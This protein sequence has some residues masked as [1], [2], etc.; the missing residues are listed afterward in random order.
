LSSITRHLK[1]PWV[2]MP[3]IAVLAV[4][5]WYV[6]AADSS[7]TDASSTQAEPQVIEAT[8]GTMSRTVAADGTVAAAETEDLSFGA[9]GTVTAV[10]VQ[11]GDAVTA[12]QVLARIDSVQLKADVAKAEASLADAK[13]KRADD[14][15]ADASDAQL[16][17]DEASITS[18]QDQLDAANE[19]LQGATLV[20]GFDGTV[21]TVNIVEGERL[22]DG[23]TGGTEVTGS[24]SGSGSSAASLGADSGGGAP[25]PGEGTSTETETTSSG[26]HI[27][28]VSA[29]RF[30]VELGFDD[31][32]IANIEVGQVATISTSSSSS[33]GFPDGGDFPLGD[34]F[35]LGGGFPGGAL[36]GADLADEDAGATGG[37]EPDLAASS[38]DGIQGLVTKVGTVADASSGVAEYPVTV[39]FVDDSGDYNVGATVSVDIV[40]EE[41]EDA[42]QVPSFAVTTTDGTSTVT[43][44]DGDSTETRTVT[45][46][47]T[48]GDMV[49]ITDGLRE[50]ESVVIEIPALG[51]LSDDAEG[52]G[53]GAGGGG[54]PEGFT[55]PAD[56]I[57]PNGGG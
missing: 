45:T 13:A 55:P 20:A 9:S 14:I 47:L 2:V 27:S 7:S 38:S 42:V 56:F 5:G 31:T 16:K 12:G 52:G 4:A 36:P 39:T 44:Q 33:T 48:S 23:G 25:S 18:A 49:Q 8:I 30:I 53:A 57:P 54:L 3:L 1:K 32:D 43:V 46:G 37:S 22:A 24:G 40:Y 41:V 26:A 35:P 11:A 15:D 34:G 19:A 50:G 6:A 28:I 21:S 17:A 10:D 29:D 51:D